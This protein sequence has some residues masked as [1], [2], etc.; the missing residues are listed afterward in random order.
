V[1]WHYVSGTCNGC[2]ARLEIEYAAVDVRVHD[3][4]SEGY[5]GVQSGTV[6]YSFAQYGLD[7]LPE[8]TDR[9]DRDD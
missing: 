9:D 8:F 4:D 2:R 3:P 6:P 7:P 5:S 1:R